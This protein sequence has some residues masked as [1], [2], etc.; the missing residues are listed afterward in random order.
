MK[1][2]QPITNGRRGQRLAPAARHLALLVLTYAALAYVFMVMQ[3]SF[4]PVPRTASEALSPQAV[5][6]A[7]GAMLGALALALPVAWVFLITRR[8]KGY[9]QSVV[10][11][12][13]VLPL[14][15][16]G[17][18]TLVQDSLPLAFGLAGIAFLRFRNNLDD[19]KD[20]VYLFVAT[21]I[22][23]SAAS[24]QFAVGLALSFLFNVTI[25]VLWWTDFARLPAR[26]K[27]RL[28]MKRL[29]QTLETRIPSPST[30]R[31]ATDPRNA[32]LRVHAADVNGAQPMVEAVLQGAAKE[33]EL[34]GVTPGQ[35]GFSTLDYVVRLRR[36]T[37]RGALL[38]DLRARG[39]PH[40]VGAE[41]R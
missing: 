11:T 1:E 38:N 34:T 15:V 40:I 27:A 26:L 9:S 32:A 12:L 39:T 4:P 37:E 29:R 10:H 7:G 3:R 18:M 13:I 41:Y 25:I 31:P 35:H 22:G 6:R 5:L 24:G 21:G 30:P 16:A 20:A 14:A 28:V 17:I 8:R 23:I 19:T 2:S 33:W 36:D